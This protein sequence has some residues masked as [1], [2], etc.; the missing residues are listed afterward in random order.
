[1]NMNDFQAHPAAREPLFNIPPLTMGLFVILLVVQLVRAASPQADQILVQS[2]VLI[3]A[4][5][6]A[7]PWTVLSY[8][9]LHF[10]W[11]H[12]AINGMG[13][14]AFGSGVEKTF[15]QT[16][17]VLILLG[18]AIGG[19][20][21]HLIL[22]S[23]SQLPLG[24][25]SAAISALFGAMLPVLT[26]GSNLWSAAIVFVITNIALGMVGLPDQPDAAI[27]WQAHL[28]GFAFG[29]I[30]ALRLTNAKIKQKI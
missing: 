4:D 24:G 30:Y 18:G 29:L 5:W 7:L 27:A 9:L 23:G 28:G 15:G 6:T 1:M 2:L 21:A 17:T 8:T 14:L 19:V 10:G 16:H 25:A 13:L 11:L 26:S 20:L 22:F 3:P 12:F